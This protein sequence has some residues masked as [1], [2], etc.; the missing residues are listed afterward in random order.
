[1]GKPYVQEMPVTHNILLVT[2]NNQHYLCD[3]GFASASPRQT[4]A[5]S[6][7]QLMTLMNVNWPIRGQQMTYCSFPVQGVH[8]EWTWMRKDFKEIE[9]RTYFVCPLLFAC[10]F[11]K[12]L[13][14]KN[15]QIS[16]LEKRQMGIANELKK[17]L[18]KNTPTFFLSMMMKSSQRQKSLAPVKEI[19]IN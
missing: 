9:G 16:N 2:I 6:Y 19:I 7:F 3:P 8:W 1:M 10:T 15:I 18:N 11:N 13:L 17:K 12:C 14:N 4:W 5:R